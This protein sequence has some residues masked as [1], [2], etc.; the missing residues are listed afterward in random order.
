MVSNGSIKYP[1]GKSILAV[2]LPLKPFP[3]TTANADIGSLKSLHIYSLFCA[4]IQWRN[5]YGLRVGKP[6]GTRAEGAPAGYPFTQA[7]QL[8]LL[9]HKGAPFQHFPILWLRNSHNDA[10]HKLIK[11]QNYLGALSKGRGVG[12]GGITSHM[13]AIIIRG[14]VAQ[15]GGFYTKKS[16]NMGLILTP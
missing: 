3:T 4:T 1:I 9:F 7:F 2:N 6:A 10:F 5:S 16:V 15:M 12:A 8:I 14:C 13:L 11:W